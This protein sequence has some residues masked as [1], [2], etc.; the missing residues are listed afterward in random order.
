VSGVGH[1]GWGHAD[2]RTRDRRG[3]KQFANHDP[4]FGVA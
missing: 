2:G 1:G 4:T 3:D